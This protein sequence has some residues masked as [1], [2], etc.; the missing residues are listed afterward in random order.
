MKKANLRKRFSG[1]MIS[2]DNMSNVSH[3][4]IEK[5][6]DDFYDVLNQNCPEEFAKYSIKICNKEANDEFD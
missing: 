1:M 2:N 3:D 6:I 5:V 4:E